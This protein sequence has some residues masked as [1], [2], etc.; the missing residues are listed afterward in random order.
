M[1]A[2]TAHVSVDVES[3]INLAVRSKFPNVN[4]RP[5]QRDGLRFILEGKDVVALLPT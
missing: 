1:A 3:V 5:E 4:I 2:A